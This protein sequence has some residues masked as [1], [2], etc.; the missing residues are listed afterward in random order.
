ML[1]ILHVLLKIVTKHLVTRADTALDFKAITVRSCKTH[2]GSHVNSN[3]PSHAPISALVCAL[4]V[5][6]ITSFAWLTAV[7]M[8]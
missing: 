3:R 5:I 8:Y 1:I 7:V 4:S 6:K 2:I